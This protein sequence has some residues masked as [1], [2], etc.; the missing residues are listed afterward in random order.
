MTVKKNLFCTKIARARVRAGI[1]IAA[2]LFIGVFGIFTLA[3]NGAN[4]QTILSVLIGAFV[5]FLVLSV[6]VMAQIIAGCHCKCGC[7]RD[8]EDEDAETDRD[9]K[10]TTR[11]H[12]VE[13]LLEE[14][15][16]LT[17]KIGERT[18]SGRDF[19][20]GA[21]GS[22]LASSSSTDDPPS[23]TISTVRER[24][25][26]RLKQLFANDLE[27]ART[28]VEQDEE[29]Q[30][31]RYAKYDKVSVLWLAWRAFVWTIIGFTAWCLDNFLCDKAPQVFRF[32]Y[33]KIRFSRRL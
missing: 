28:R 14:I 11:E 10:L 17:A 25:G 13:S 21:I 22:A 3:V 18:A 1:S 2:A 7:G 33:E 12:E 9:A 8:Q 23:A 16:S 30:R 4:S 5:V 15:T 6:F 27:A 29:A 26:A 20:A 19:G 31:K 24:L 32:G